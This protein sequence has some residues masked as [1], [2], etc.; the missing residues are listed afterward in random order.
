M[1]AILVTGGTGLVGARLLPRLMGEG[2]ECRALLRGDSTAPEGIATVR[3]D[4]L[5]P[6]SLVAAVQGV[7]AVV[8]LAAHFRS[9]DDEAMWRVNHEG[10]RNLIGALRRHA[11]QARCIMASTILVYDSDSPRPGRECDPATPK[12]A[13]PASKLAAEEDLKASGLTWSILRLGFVYGEQDGHL[14]MVPKIMERFG[15]HPAMAFSLIHHLDV[16]A[17]VKLGLSGALDGRIV[18]IVD[19]A[20]TTAWEMACV[21]GERMEPSAAPLEHPWRGRVDGSLA[22]SL[23]FQPS[24]ATL[25][26]AARERRL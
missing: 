4:L 13:Y 14:E 7:Q 25:W 17:A 11:P 24:V 6:E 10:T 21:V 3:G 9:Q 8:H 26:Q 15:W 2:V 19:D 22:R 23:G 12:Q 1:S 5:Q 18:N 20:P 16:A